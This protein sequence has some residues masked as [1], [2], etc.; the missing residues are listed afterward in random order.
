MSNFDWD[1][2]EQATNEQLAE[3]ILSKQGDRPIEVYFMRSA[4]VELAK[5]ITPNTEVQAVHGATGNKSQGE[6]RPRNT[7]MQ[8]A[9]IEN[10]EGNHD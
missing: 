7:R 8:K 2:L 6:A 3:A 5:R 4:A 1:N 9:V 10:W